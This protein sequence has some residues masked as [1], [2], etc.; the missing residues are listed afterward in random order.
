MLIVSC[1]FILPRLRKKCNSLSYV[2]F[3][4]FFAGILVRKFS[5]KVGLEQE[6]LTGL[7][8]EDL[9][10]GK[11][12]TNCLVKRKAI[13]AYVQNAQVQALARRREER[14]NYLVSHVFDIKTRIFAIDSVFMESKSSSFNQFGYSDLALE[15]DKFV[16]LKETSLDNLSKLPICKVVLI[17]IPRINGGKKSF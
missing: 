8:M 1:T 9:G 16:L 17:D 2:F 11:W 3:N 12:P 6:C 4:G 15:K 10:A 13:K 5:F 14:F 7:I